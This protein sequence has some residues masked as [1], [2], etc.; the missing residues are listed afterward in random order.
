MVHPV[1]GWIL[2]FRCLPVVSVPVVS[3]PVVSVPGRG[4]AGT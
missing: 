1:A 3:V 2:N 4:S